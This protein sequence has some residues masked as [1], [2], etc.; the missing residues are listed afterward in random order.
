VAGR[1]IERNIPQ[2]LDSKLKVD[3]GALD[4]AVP[5]GIADR[6]E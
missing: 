3:T 4:V 2:I 1:E 5:Q 6:L